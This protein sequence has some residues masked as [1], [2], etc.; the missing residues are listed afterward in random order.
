MMSTKT[1]MNP[2]K[3]PDIGHSIWLSLH[4]NQKRSRFN[5]F[6]DQKIDPPMAG[7]NPTSPRAASPKARPAS[8]SPGPAGFSSV[9]AWEY[10][11]DDAG[12]FHLSFSS[13]SQ[14]IALAQTNGL[15]AI[16]SPRTGR[17]SYSVPFID[18]ASIVT[19]AKFHPRPEQRLLLAA[20]TSGHL[21]LCQYARPAFLWQTRELDTAI[22]TGDFSVDG[23]LFA[24]AGK[25]A[26]VR[27]YDTDQHRLRQTFSNDADDVHHASRIHSLVFDKNE[28]SVLATGGW[29][30][31][32][33]L[34]DIRQA[35]AV[36][37]IGGPNICGDSLDLCGTYL[38]A[39]SWRLDLPLEVWDLRRPQEAMARA[40]WGG[41]DDCQIY[42]AK[43]CQSERWIIAGGSESHSAK[44]FAFTE[45]APAERLGYFERAVVSVGVSGDGRTAVAASQDGKCFGFAKS[46]K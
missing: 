39:G 4:Q 13:N 42:A 3:S 32:V 44:T 9:P 34:W 43:F 8:P 12:I 10:T 37:S 19:I 16:I 38:L 15:I 30:M 1:F 31:R 28:P 20:G 2:D 40:E 25:D 36:A 29:D 5:L 23:S 46:Y 27:I 6:F 17:V 18:P 45:L 41:S 7:S 11:T 24:T 22:F 35:T 21:G 14:D 26:I 33:L